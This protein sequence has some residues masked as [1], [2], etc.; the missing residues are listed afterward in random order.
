MINGTDKPCVHP[1]DRGLAYGDGVFETVAIRDGRLRLI[2]YHL[3]RLELGCARLGFAAP[4]RDCLSAELS[5]LAQNL[6]HAT[7]KII[8]TRGVGPRGYRPPESPEPTRIIGVEATLPK[9]GAAVRRG[10]RVRSCDTRLAGNPLLA[11]IKTLNRL[12]QVLARAEWSD[13]A[14]AEGLMCNTAGDV[15]CGTMSNVFVVRGKCLMTPEL[16]DCG[17]RGVMRRFVLETARELGIDTVEAVLPLQA[18]HQAD[19]LFL[20]NSQFGI[21]PVAEWEGQ[22]FAA[23]TLTRQ[24]MDALAERGIEECAA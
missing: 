5:G 12:E 24:L 15:I 6:R 8:V 23:G 9:S 7:G 10:V 1:Q 22:H 19:E 16:N 11:G 3:D 21:W 14:I 17:V 4:V 13:P 20:T 18:L 2:D